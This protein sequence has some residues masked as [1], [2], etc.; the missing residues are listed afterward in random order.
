M[1]KVIVL[2]FLAVAALACDKELYTSIPDS[3]VSFTVHLGDID[4][5]LNTGTAYKTFKSKRAETDRI[6]YGGLLVV[7]SPGSHLNN[8]TLYAYDLACPYEVRREIRVN[9]VNMSGSGKVPTAITAV[10]PECGSEFDIS[11]GTGQ[12]MKGSK[13]K[14]GLKVY[15]V[16]KQANQRYHISR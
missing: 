11:N 6:G 16:A 15:H 7:S 1:K 8:V 10:C 3:L 5:D 13:A 4:A 9:P 2:L 12:P 14:Y